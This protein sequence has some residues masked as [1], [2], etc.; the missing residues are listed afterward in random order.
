[1]FDAHV[2][3][4]LI[5]S[6]GDTHQ[7][8]DAIER[9]IHGW[10]NAR[11]EREQIMLAPWRWETH[12]V[13]EMGGVAQTIIDR[14]AVDECDLVLAVFNARLGT[15]TLDAVSGTAHE[16]LRAHHAGKP[17]HVWFSAAPIPRETRP[18]ELKRLND[19]QDQLRGQSLLGDYSGVE[20]LQFK[21][22]DAI[23]H[24]LKGLDLGRVVIR[25]GKADQ[26]RKVLSYTMSVSILGDGAW[27]V[28]VHNHSNGPITGLRVHV[29][30]VDDTG[31]VIP[32]AV[33]RS[34]DVF[35]NQ[36]AFAR[37]IGDAF[38]GGLTP[39]LGAGTAGFASRAMGPAAQPHLKAALVA[40]MADGYPSG[41]A[42]DQQAMVIFVLP[43]GSTPQ[44]SI[45]FKDETGLRWS[46]LNDNEP[47]RVDL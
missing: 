37:V 18:E 24:D 13:P 30:A 11:A 6:P 1:M 28:T 23:E 35:S 20:D 43:A 16:I 26:A 19:F 47:Q 15:A 38:A 42:P 25:S 39:V 12:A 9:A 29:D 33:R 31:H 10:N 44:V 41:L 22:R 3:K 14:Q 45:E 2:L 17:V 27:R 21:V 36:D 4:A 34:K 8:R 5:A 32:D 7:E 40:H 46:R